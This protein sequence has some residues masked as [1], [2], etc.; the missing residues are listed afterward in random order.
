M[1]VGT[2]KKIIIIFFAV[3]ISL[4]AAEVLLRIFGIEPWK[5]ILT[6]DTINGKNIY[7]PDTTLG[8]KAKEGDYFLLPTNPLDKQF[9]ISI[10]KNG[11]RKTGENIESVNG[12]ILVI[13]GSF[14][15]GWG[16]NNKDTFS[17]K[18]QK[19]FNN[20]KVYNFGQAGYGTIQS[21]LLLKKQISEM[22]V[23]KLI[24]YG[25]IEHHEYRNAARSQWL[26]TLAKYSRRGTVRT[27]Y[28]L[29]GKNNK[30]IIYPPT[31]YINLPLR[32][33]SALITLFEK[34]Y[35]KNI[36]TK[37]FPRDSKRKKYQKL[38]TEKAVLQMK[39]ISKKFGANFIVVI[40][41]W[42]NDLTKDK[43]EIF[44]KENKIKFVNCKTLLIDEMVLKDDYHPSEKAHSYYNECLVDY[45]EEQKLIF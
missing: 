42:S 22:K 28:G 6:N 9:H 43:Y 44:F 17:S 41:D 5:N 27:P 40:L 37:E 1:T 29:I 34:A 7:T 39:E 8:W 16:V 13:G 2:S 30:L 35:M 32:E 10:E 3:I 14:S 20:F 24:I 18:L 23:P 45:I 11:N 33:S 25:F 19:K 36:S 38:V 15:L 31:G 26:R 12:E 21:L 4:L